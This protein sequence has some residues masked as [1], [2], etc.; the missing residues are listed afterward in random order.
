MRRRRIAPPTLVGFPL[1]NL[2]ERLQSN[3]YPWL[4]VKK[5]CEVPKV[6]RHNTLQTFFLGLTLLEQAAKMLAGLKSVRVTVAIG[7]KPQ[8]SQCFWCNENGNSNEFGKGPRG[9]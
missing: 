4:R 6:L 9:N 3:S 1:I 8:S 7:S 5:I 2:E